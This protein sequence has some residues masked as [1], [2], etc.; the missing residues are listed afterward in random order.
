[1]Q[2][3]NQLSTLLASDEEASSLLLR[4]KSSL[5]GHAFTEG[6]ILTELFDNPNLVKLL[7]RDFAT[8]FRPPTAPHEKPEPQQAETLPADH[9]AARARLKHVCKSEREAVIFDAF[10]SFNRYTLKT[11]FYRSRKVALSFRLDPAFLNYKLHPTRPYG[12]FFV[13]GAEFRGFHVRFADVARGGI[14]LVRSRFVQE[15]VTNLAGVFDEAY[16]LASTQQRK[17]KDIPEGGSKGV[18]L[19]NFAHQVRQRALSSP[20]FFLLSLAAVL[21]TFEIILCDPL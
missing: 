15:F 7:Y 1:M 20:P 3:V 17:N 21:L 5:A 19:L 13:I 14:R 11:N 9:A 8:R 2:E 18:V 4:L 16:N 12:V 10:L 6:T